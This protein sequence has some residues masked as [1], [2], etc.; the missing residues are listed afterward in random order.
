MSQTKAPNEPSY[1]KPRQAAEYLN[2]SPSTLAKRRL[3]GG[4]PR[5][6]KIG[7][8]VRY[9]KHDLDE[10]M[11]RNTVSSTFEEAGR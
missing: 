5:F 8:S 1:F 4:G 9:A 3:Y 6:I 7:R 11:A 2:S 10:F